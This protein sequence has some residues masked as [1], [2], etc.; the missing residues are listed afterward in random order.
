MQRLSDID[1]TIVLAYLIGV[2][3]LGYFLGKNQKT[4][5]DYFLG[6]RKL[7][8]WMVG[9]SLVVSDIGAL[10]LMGVSGAAYVYGFSLA[11]LDW[12]ACL[13]PMV[14]AAF[15]FIPLFW[16]TG[17]Y[18]IPEYI[19]RRYHHGVRTLVA[20]IWGCFMVANLGIFLW[21]SAKALNILV[22]W[23]IQTSTLV[24]AAVVGTYTFF[25]GLKA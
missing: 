1:I 5:Q 8:W 19:G 6:G 4:D 7:K 23:P 21:V 25:G 17:I 2:L 20:L 12:L 13:F 3:I 15:L 11:N 22:G 10:E 18:T 24:T 9:P 14:L 16:K